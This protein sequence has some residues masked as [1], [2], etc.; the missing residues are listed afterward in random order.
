MHPYMNLIR[1]L[2]PCLLWAWLPLRGGAQALPAYHQ[3]ETGGYTRTFIVHLPAGY[4]GQSP[5][6]VV[7]MFHG[8]S[9]N[10][11][12]FFWISGWKEKADAE[13]FI[14]VFPDGLSYCIEEDGRRKQTTKWNDGKLET[15]VCPG[16]ALP[17][18]VQFV[19]DM[20]RYLDS[21]FVIDRRRVFASG[22]SNGAQ[23]VFRL[24]IEASDVIAAVA[25][26]GGDLTLSDPVAPRPIPVFQVG[27]AA[28]PGILER[29][30]GLPM[31]S[32][33]EALR[34]DSL[35]GPIMDRWVAVLGLGDTYDTQ[36]GDWHYAV[37]F[38]AG[39]GPYIFA[40]VKGLEHRYP[41]GGNNPAGYVAADRF[42]RFFSR[43][44]MP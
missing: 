29:R 23:F 33:P 43:H 37:G 34:T 41:N 18:D 15:Y 28:D 35:F 42:W 21:A 2:L 38:E 13:G 20:V 30:G 36:S 14:A 9:G 12:K 17:D 7:F 32:S 24:A 10:G 44:P 22:F 6:P 1:L 40:L 3:L 16:Q 19:R 11:E 39:G 26:V 8:S 4:T 27:G 31:P 5:L 25:G